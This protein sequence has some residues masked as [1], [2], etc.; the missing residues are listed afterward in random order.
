MTERNKDR[1]QDGSR[2]PER[3]AWAGSKVCSLP[4]QPL[5]SRREGDP[6]LYGARSMRGAMIHGW[7]WPAPQPCRAP[8][9]ARTTLDDMRLA[10]EQRS[11][12][13]RSANGLGRP[14]G[15][16]AAASEADSRPHGRHRRSTRRN[17]RPALA[18]REPASAPAANH[19]RGRAPDASEVGQAHQVDTVICQLLTFCRCSSAPPAKQWRRLFLYDLPTCSKWPSPCR[20]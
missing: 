7:F 4:T 2:R 5:I 13:E 15:S 12:C 10:R 14:S 19:R 3:E 17:S 8:R 6:S 11:P 9:P 20:P 16:Q 1:N 18:G